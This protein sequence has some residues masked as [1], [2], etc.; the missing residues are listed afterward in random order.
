MGM[1]ERMGTRPGNLFDTKLAMYWQCLYIGRRSV[2]VAMGKKKKTLPK[3][4]EELIEVGDISTLKD[5]FSQCEWDACGG[6][7]KAT[8]LSFYKIPDEL[9]YW[10]VE[11]GAD[12]NAKDNYK[13]TPLHSQAISWC[14]NVRLFLELGA[15]IEA[16]D[17]KN[18][19]PLHVAAGAFKSQAVQELVV[20]GANINAKNNKKYTPLAK[21]L[22]HCRNAD[23]VKMVE[24][25]Q[26]LLD[27]GTPIT[28]DMIESVKQI[29]KDF[30]FYKENFNKELLRQTVDSLF[31]LYE[32]F[33]VEP[34]A[35]R[36]IHDGISPITV[37]AT[38][39]QAQHEELWDFLISAQGYAKTIQGEIIRI[40]G[41]VAHE[42]L[43][44][45]GI[46]WDNDYRKMLDALI[47]YF[48]AGT[49]LVAATL[50]EATTLA[51]QLR[52]GIGDDEPARLCELAVQWVLANPNPIF[53]KQPDYK[54]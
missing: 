31:R 13:R 22:A 28:L 44:N 33:N 34:V 23:I 51:K 37:T 26:I 50:Q 35:K 14:G 42:I 8:A 10:L 12:I 9:V 25:A 43:D 53:L 52:N 6:Y 19:T 15:D 20:H 3:N 5:V 46:N 36:H 48:M 11:Q 45:G 7:S 49:P 41:R 54:R 1:R 40:T 4:F 32:Q 30:E 38:Y 27:A 21:A 29:G 24:I 17:S 18:E 2:K 47:S 39:W 16:V